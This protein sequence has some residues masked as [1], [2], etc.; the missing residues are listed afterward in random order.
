[1]KYNIHMEKLH[2]LL[3]SVNF[4]KM[5]IPHVSSTQTEKEY[6]T[7]HPVSPPCAL[8]GGPQDHPPTGLS[9]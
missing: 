5:S 9:I 1:M 3:N 7:N 4:H 6:T 2:K 8:C